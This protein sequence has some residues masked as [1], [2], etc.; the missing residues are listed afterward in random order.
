MTKASS[1]GLRVG[2]DIGGTFTDLVFVRP[3]SK[4]DRR[5]LPSTPVNYA[6]A[7]LDGIEKYCSEQDY[8]EASIREIT[9]ATTV[10]TNAILERKGVKTALITTEGFRDI[11]ELRRIRVPLSYNL[12]W[13]KPV[14]LVDRALRFTVR[15]RLDSNGQ[16]LEPLVLE[17]LKPLLEALSSE[18]VE[19]VAVCLLHSYRQP[20]H[21]QLIGEL[22]RKHFPGL[23]ISLS[24][25][26]LPEILEFERTS[27]TVVNAYVA[28]LIARYLAALRSKL[29]SRS[30]RAPI[31]VMQSNGGL[32]S[33]A[34]AA[35]RPVTIIESGP[36]AG[37][38]AATRIARAAGYADV[39]TFDMGGTTT[40]ASIIEKGDV[41]RA[42]EYEV[43]APISV[44][45]RM[46]RGGGYLLRIPVIDISEV[47][48]GGGSIATVDP[49]GALRVGPRSAGADPGPA[50]YGKGNSEPTVTDANLVLGYLTA[51]SLVGGNLVVDP[52]RA[53]ASIQQVIATPIGLSLVEAAHGIHLVANSNM[54]RAIK[55]VSV[56]RG[57]DPADFVLMAFGGAGP[58][59]AA[60]LA[61]S[62]GIRTVIIPPSPGVFSAFGLIGAKIEYH[63]SRTVLVSTQ[64]AP[65]AGLQRVLNAM[66]EDVV[67]RLRA[68]GIDERMVQCRGFVDM[69]YRGQSSDLTIALDDLTLNARNLVQLERSF[70]Q[71]FQRTYGHL[72]P[73]RDFE[74][75]TLRL[76]AATDRGDRSNYTWVAPPGGITNR[77][78]M[79]YFGPSHGT[80]RAPVLSRSDLSGRA[81][82]GPAIIQEYDATIVV[83]P[84]STAKLDVNGCVVV[85]VTTQC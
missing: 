41:L 39:I 46:V 83:P 32:I 13:Q 36:A 31:L 65:I 15:E 84:A 2:V 51:D 4:L 35:E 82:S 44:S 79:C 40:K 78:R 25:Q 72:G 59:H 19:A 66:R 81:L 54:V 29:E 11:L 68:E 73:K 14:P 42:S 22:L 18:A 38:V 5:K 1:A 24:H 45:S 50:C 56:E 47:G 10:A 30:V 8:A 34:S 16:V 21:E 27:T 26:I 6:E 64:D 12:D 37:V 23:H 55:S 9:H 52:A 49:G 62:L 80:V 75:V 77:E 61:R 70:E 76:V 53:E 63:A 67:G 58:I 17:S 74:L 71:E 57:R 7:I 43:G 60:A 28:P 48:A 33:A 3:D 20:V 69:R 85:E